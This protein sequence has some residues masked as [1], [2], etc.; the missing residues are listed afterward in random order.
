MPEDLKSFETF[1]PKAA[2]V[3]SKVRKR[4]GKI[5]DF[6]I[7]RISTAVYKAMQA[8]EEGGEADSRLVAERVLESLLK[9]QTKERNF[10]PT[11]EGIQDVVEKELILGGFV[12]TSKTYILYREKHADIRKKQKQVPEHIKQL[13]EESKKYFKNQLSEFVYYTTYSKWI[14]EERRRETWIETISRYIDFMR[15]NVGDKLTEKEYE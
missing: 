10:V 11:V 14:P 3:I 4:D 2:G 5:V 9:M 7:T 1:S 8:A 13:A 12:K 6:D 15:E